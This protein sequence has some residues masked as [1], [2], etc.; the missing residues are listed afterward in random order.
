MGQEVGKDHL[1][2]K[3]GESI[4]SGT[5][6]FS[7]AISGAAGGERKGGGL[8]DKKAKAKHAE[9]TVRSFLR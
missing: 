3:E 4:W 1:F 2:Q 5:R 9:V 6:A 7:Q 8:V